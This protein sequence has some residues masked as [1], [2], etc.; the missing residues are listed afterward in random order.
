MLTEHCRSVFM[1]FAADRQIARS[2][3]H[4]CPSAVAFDGFLSEAMRRPPR[5]R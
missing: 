3:T 5:R 4:Q 2:L 1:Q